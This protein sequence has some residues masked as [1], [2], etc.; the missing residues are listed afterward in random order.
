MSRK[1][2]VVG[3][4][5]I[6][7]YNFIELVKENFDEVLLLTNEVNPEKDVSAVEVDFSLGVQSFRTIDKIRKIFREFQPSLVHI[8]QANT[9]AFLTVL[10]LKNQ[11][12]PLVLT[13]WGSDILLN[14]KKSFLLKKMVQYILNNVQVVTADSNHVLNSAQQLV[15]KKLSLH[16]VNFGITIENCSIQIKENIIYSNRLHTDLYNIDKVIISFSKFVQDNKDWKL[17]IAGRGDQTENLKFFVQTLHLDE[18]V[19]FV[20]FLNQEENY[21]YYCRSKVYVSIPQSDSISIS[22]VEAIICGCIPFVSNL[23]ANLELIVNRKN[24]FIEDNLEAIDFGKF[25]DI[26]PTYFE[27][28][29]EEVKILFSKGYNKKKYFTIYEELGLL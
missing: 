7:V 18:F 5:L 12:V 27:S 9:Y 26:D 15:D 3:S 14:P 4:N 29:R 21:K 17:V 19:E 22:L 20:G 10:A 23:E 24:G 6:H 28:T 13:A 8:Q 25:G 16:N 11:H 1:L 2:L